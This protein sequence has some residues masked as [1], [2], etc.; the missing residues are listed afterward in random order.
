MTKE[1][2]LVRPGHFTHLVAGDGDGSRTL[3][4]KDA[5][6]WEHQPVCPQCLEQFAAD[7]AA[8]RSDR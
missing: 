1:I 8:N 2:V 5:R 3:C 4:G 6:W 7:I